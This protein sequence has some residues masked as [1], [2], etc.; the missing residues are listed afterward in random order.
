MPRVADRPATHDVTPYAPATPRY[1]PFGRNNKN[2][3]ASRVGDDFA[4]ELATNHVVRRIGDA[5][6][7]R[8]EKHEWQEWYGVSGEGHKHGSG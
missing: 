7:Q 6:S 8:A 5:E 3:P 4:R 2:A 1:L